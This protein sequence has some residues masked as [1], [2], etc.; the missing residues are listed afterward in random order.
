MS[1]PEAVDVCV[2]G[3]GQSALALGYYLR[4][5]ERRRAE[6][7]PL[8]VVILDRR[9]RPGGAWLDAW[10]SLRLFSPAGYSSLPG[11][12][13]PSPTGGA[14]P[15]AA[16]VVDY[17]SDY[18]VRYGLDVRRPVRVIDITEDH[19]DNDNGA[20]GHLVVHTDRGPVRAR[21]V[22]NA[23]GTWDRPLWPSVAGAAEFEGRQLHTH[24]YRGP[25]E[26]SGARVLV[27]GGGNS[28]AQIAA[29]L[30]GTAAAVHWVTRHPPR[31]L[32]D[33]VDGRV[34]FEVATRAVADRAAGRP[35]E[36]VGSLGDIVA[37]PSVRAARDRGDLVAEPMVATLTA[38]GARWPDGRTALL[39]AVI[40]ATGFRPALSHLRGLDLR[41]SKGLPLTQ[42]P[43]GSAS[44]VRSA[45]G[46][47][48]WFLGYG[49]WCGP[50]SA[51]LIGVG[52][53]ARDTAADVVRRLDAAR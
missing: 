31:Y 9:D 46:R 35:A 29:D 47:P 13:M 39:D 5:A 16:H 20:P 22:V 36:G 30:I 23:T 12:L 44:A 40:W 26:L 14:D 24:D 3:G 8:S 49:D 33:D 15:D 21:A 27:V 42:A 50:A 2:V 7:R 48:L 51:T 45:D 41:R 4:R 18:E 6:R 10:P 1:L 53:P 11:R 38:Q 37:V 52:R 32:P 28:G 43:P 17:L 19:D 25:A 34:L